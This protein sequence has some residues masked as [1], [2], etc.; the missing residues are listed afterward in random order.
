MLDLELLYHTVEYHV[1]DN[2]RPNS[3][4]AVIPKIPHFRHQTNDRRD[5]RKLG[6]SR[7]WIS[8]SF[9]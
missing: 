3:I 2:V 6:F 9:R 1:E 4:Q 7:C 5:Q 8:T